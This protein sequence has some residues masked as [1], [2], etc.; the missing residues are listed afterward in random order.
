MYNDSVIQEQ[1]GLNAFITKS[2]ISWDQC[3]DFSPCLWGLMMT[4]FQRFLR[5]NLEL[6]STNGFAAVVVGV[7]LVFVASGRLLKIAVYSSDLLDLLSFEWSTLGFIIASLHASIVYRLS[8]SV[9]WCLLSWGLSDASVKKD[10]NAGMGRALMGVLISVIILLLWTCSWEV[11]EWTISCLSSSLQ[12]WQQDKDSLLSMISKWVAYY[13][14]GSSNN[15]NFILTL[16]TSLSSL[17][18]IFGRND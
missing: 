10:L 18:R 13:R 3:W 16:S 12:D 1:S 11:L 17:L 9:P 5:S 6:N 2:L 15:W 14:L 7:I 4:V 8:W